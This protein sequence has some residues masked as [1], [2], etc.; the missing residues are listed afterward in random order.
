MR[1]SLPYYHALQ[2][3]NSYLLNHCQWQLP[4]WMCCHHAVFDELDREM[5]PTDSCFDGWCW[6]KLPKKRTRDEKKR[7]EVKDLNTEF[8]HWKWCYTI[9]TVKTNTFRHWVNNIASQ[10]FRFKREKERETLYIMARRLLFQLNSFLHHT[11]WIDV[12]GTILWSFQRRFCTVQHA[13]PVTILANEPQNLLG[14]D[15]MCGE[16]RTPLSL[17]IHYFCNIII[18]VESPK[19]C[20][21]WSPW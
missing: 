6:Y 18:N 21:W 11:Y 15:Q 5:L 16:N 12:K 4:C 20:I 2:R 9:T 13:N 10:Y 7:K 14:F 8:Q 17:S 1:I 19:P 3:L